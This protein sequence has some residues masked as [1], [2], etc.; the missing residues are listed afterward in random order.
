MKQG[1]GKVATGDILGLAVGI[2]RRLALDHR[3]N[4]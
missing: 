3:N 1:S 4:S 2:L